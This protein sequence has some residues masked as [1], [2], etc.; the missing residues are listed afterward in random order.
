MAFNNCMDTTPAFVSSNIAC[1]T[2]STAP[3]WHRNQMC[4]HRERLV[5]PTK[6]NTNC[7][8]FSA[9]SS[10]RRFSIRMGSYPPNWAVRWVS[11][12]STRLW[13][14]SSCKL[15]CSDCN[16]CPVNRAF[17]H[18]ALSISLG[19]NNAPFVGPVLVGG[20]NSEQ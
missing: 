7:F 18:C 5:S 12:F 6:Q 13:W 8:F 10:M 4:F 11:P 19:L 17:F 14:Y 3:Y 15:S 20:V 16:P 9:A 1:F 2:C